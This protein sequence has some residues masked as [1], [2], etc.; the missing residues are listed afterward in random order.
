MRSV[1]I[2]LQQVCSASDL[3]P[4][5]AALR[6]LQL[7]PACRA[8]GDSFAVERV[9][10]VAAD[11]ANRFHRTDHQEYQKQGTSILDP[12]FTR[13][14]VAHYRCHQAGELD[15]TPNTGDLRLAY[16]LCDL[17]HDSSLPVIDS[18]EYNSLLVP[19]FGAA[20]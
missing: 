2:A 1:E 8:A 11:P 7:T 3:L 13:Q 5:E 17:C 10:A 9:L 20:P 18:N 4:Y 12:G 19:A 14:G 6:L 16:Y 15:P